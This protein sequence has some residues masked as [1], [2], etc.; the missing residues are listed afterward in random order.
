MLQLADA[1][2][3]P[4]LLSRNG[5]RARRAEWS[6]C[7]SLGG[8]IRVR[9]TF[10]AGDCLADIV[11]AEVVIAVIGVVHRKMRHQRVEHL[12]VY[13]PP[14]EHRVKHMAAEGVVIGE[15]MLMESGHGGPVEHH[16]GEVAKHG[17]GHI[18][19]EEDGL[20][21]RHFEQC[22][23]RCLLFDHGTSLDE[24]ERPVHNH[25]EER[26][27][28]AVGLDDAVIELLE[29][30]VLTLALVLECGTMRI[31]ERH[32]EI[33]R[34]PFGHA[35]LAYLVGDTIEDDEFAVQS[36]AGADACVAVLEQFADG[37]G[38]LQQ[39]GYEQREC[40]VL[41]QHVCAVIGDGTDVLGQ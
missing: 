12:T 34:D 23:I 36:F 35:G 14:A 10:G 11:L 25:G 26:V 27:G 13:L 24:A 8:M 7:S 32:G 1:V 5:W 22:G 20:P 30:D 17:A 18:M 31:G 21:V 40:A 28:S 15:E 41:I 38:A 16:G 3:V 9:V 2:A 37:G 4:T 39:A 19:S 6:A 29:A 33:V